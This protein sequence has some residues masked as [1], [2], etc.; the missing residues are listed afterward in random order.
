MFFYDFVGVKFT[1]D[2][3]EYGREIKLG[4][5]PKI[6]KFLPNGMRLVR[7]EMPNL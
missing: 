6:H 5:Y 4:I 7:E 2:P 1:N 3:A